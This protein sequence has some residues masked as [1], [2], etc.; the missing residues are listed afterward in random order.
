MAF[1]SDQLNC[2]HEWHL[3][4][5]DKNNGSKLGDGASGGP[6]LH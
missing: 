1:K 5:V 3:E 4:R 6:T 2:M